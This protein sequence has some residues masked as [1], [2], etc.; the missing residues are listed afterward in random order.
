MVMNSSQIS[1]MVGG[2]MAQFSNQQ[3]YA[4]Q[5]SGLYGTGPQSQGPG[6]SN[7]FP[8][9]AGAGMV[10]A[11]VSAVGTIGAAASM[12]GGFMGGTAAF[13]DPFA[14]VMHGFSAGRAAAG[15]AGAMGM[16]GGLGLA[17]ATGGMYAVGG[18]MVTGALDNIGRG[19]QDVADVGML[20]G[21]HMGPQF[22]QPGAR[23]GG[24]MGRSQ[25]RQ[26]TA[27]ME[28]L[29]SDDVMVTMDSLKRLMDK[30]GQSGML[31]GIGDAQQFKSKFG[32]MVK[33]M[34][35][36]AEVMGTSLEEAAPLFGQM[37]QMGMW[38]TS[39]IMG[40]SGALKAA[41]AAAPQLM[42]TMQQGA[43]MSHAMGG[44]LAAGA[45]QGREMF[46]QVQAAQGA[47]VLSP[48]MLREFTGG[49]GG[50]QGQQMMA[51]QMQGVVGQFGKTSMGRMMMAGLGKFEKGKFT[52]GIDESA[53]CCKKRGWGA[54]NWHPLS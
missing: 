45:I 35:S 22:G 12:A 16:A 24:G 36:M 33:Q 20:A 31:Q 41:G 51:Q 49:V 37:Q 32:G 29:A 43:Q 34:K 52:G 14:G 6:M 11:G 19:A 28:E 40:T 17:A 30:A 1:G 26:M 3:A 48:E 21:Q 9:G 53:I 18:A 23:A 50:A 38:K 5:I 8:E 25:I 44:T 46:S 54:N 15:G 39:D 27:V 13:A 42:N 7:P 10:N 2:Q 4:Q 47:G